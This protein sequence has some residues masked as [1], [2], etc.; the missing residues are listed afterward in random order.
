LKILFFPHQNSR[1]YTRK[2]KTIQI[3]LKFLVET[4]EKNSQKWTLFPLSVFFLQR[5]WLPQKVEMQ[6]FYWKFLELLEKNCQFYENNFFL[7]KLNFI[8]F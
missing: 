2:T 7:R 5:I 8:T 6:I 1:N 4:W 3:L